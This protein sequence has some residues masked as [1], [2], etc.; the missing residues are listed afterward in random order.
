MTDLKEKHFC[1]NCNQE[2]TENEAYDTFDKWCKFCG[3]KDGFITFEDTQNISKNHTSY[4]YLYL[5]TLKNSQSS[6]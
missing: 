6:Y 5:E 1:N 3:A 4:V 2:L